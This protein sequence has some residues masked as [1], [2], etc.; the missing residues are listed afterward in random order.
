M[1][2]KLTRNSVFRLT[3]CGGYVSMPS[4]PGR[5]A[6]PRM[7]MC[8]AHLL[9]YIL[10]CVIGVVGS[11]GQGVGVP[12]DVTPH[13]SR[14]SS[15]FLLAP[16]ST[17]AMAARSAAMACSSV[18]FEERS[19]LDRNN[20]AVWTAALAPSANVSLAALCCIISAF[21]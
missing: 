7:A 11:T 4:R 2:L 15:H 20:A 6:H 3:A 5:I 12:I 1:R 18:A 17:S 21:K 9:A 13:M 8:V 19:A 16:P 14:N 10:M